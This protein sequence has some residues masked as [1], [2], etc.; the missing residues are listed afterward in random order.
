MQMNSISTCCVGS[1]S[2]ALVCVPAS[3]T[4]TGL[5]RGFRTATAPASQDALW[6]AFR[7]VE[8]ENKREDRVW[9]VLAGCAALILLLSFSGWGRVVEARVLS[10][11]RPPTDG[12]FQVSW[13]PLGLVPATANL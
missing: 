9:L 13:E 4:R 5:G 8:R 7:E 2:G 12:T 11:L 6:R 3:S 10:A 1:E